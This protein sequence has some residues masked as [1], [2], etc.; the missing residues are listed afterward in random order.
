V[1][2]RGYVTGGSFNASSWLAEKLL[3]VDPQMPPS[4]L[5][6]DGK[7]GFATN[8]FGFSVG[9]LIGQAVVV[10]TS[11]NLLNWRPLQTK[12]LDAPLF[13][14]SDPASSNVSASFYRV[15]LLP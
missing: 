9:G 14:F 4:I 12:S 3:A 13:Y 5:M 11:T 8:A 10:E 6:R 2:A 7:F 1:R 15:R